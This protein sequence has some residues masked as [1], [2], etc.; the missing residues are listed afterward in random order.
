[1]TSCMRESRTLDNPELL[2]TRFLHS[3]LVARM[4]EVTPGEGEDPGGCH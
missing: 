2:M 4:A 1:M 3:E